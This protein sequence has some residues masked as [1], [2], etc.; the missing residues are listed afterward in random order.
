M[1][2]HAWKKN[3]VKSNVNCS[4]EAEV[5]EAAKNLNIEFSSALLFGIKFRAAEIS[6]TEFPNNL[7]SHKLERLSERLEEANRRIEELE[8]AT[9]GGEK[10][11]SSRLTDRERIESYPGGYYG[12]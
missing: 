10:K 11:F 4:I 6:E 1:R 9:A 12:N 5:K 2:A 8:G 3:M 7:L